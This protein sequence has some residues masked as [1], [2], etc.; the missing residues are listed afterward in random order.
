MTVKMVTA[1]LCCA[2]Q[3]TTPAISLET[4]CDHSII[5]VMATL[6]ELYDTMDVR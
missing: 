5:A 2:S 6:V 3:A 4:M 1:R